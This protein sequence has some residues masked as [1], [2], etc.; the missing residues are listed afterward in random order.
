MNPAS[1]SFWIKKYPDAKIDHDYGI[2][3][4]ARNESNVI[5]QLIHSIQ[6]NDYDESKIKIFVIADN[7]ADNTAEVV[8]DAVVGALSRINEN[9]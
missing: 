5:A 2:L 1:V 4:A 6:N 9:G 7:C 3:I 8:R